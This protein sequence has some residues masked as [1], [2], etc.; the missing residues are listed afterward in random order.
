MCF[1]VSELC[2]A[3]DGVTIKRVNCSP[4][5]EGGEGGI[6]MMG[7]RGSSGALRRWGAM[8]GDG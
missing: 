8:G 7:G 3:D 2:V 5:L 1:V 4:I 6:G